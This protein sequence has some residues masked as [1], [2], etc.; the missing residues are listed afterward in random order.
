MDLVERPL[1]PAG[2]N[3][4]H[5]VDQDAAGDDD[6]RHCH[7]DESEIGKDDPQRELEYS[8]G[9]DVEHAPQQTR[10]S[11]PTGNESIE[12]VEDQDNEKDRDRQQADDGVAQ[13]KHQD[14]NE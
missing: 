13:V 8:V 9:G 1:P 11:T 4:A 2:P 14:E 6:Q 12:R 5:T 3:A 10:L 7:R